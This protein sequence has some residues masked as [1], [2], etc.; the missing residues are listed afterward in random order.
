MTQ[1][2]G[3][4]VPHRFEVIIDPHSK[5]SMSAFKKILRNF[6]VVAIKIEIIAEDPRRVH[7]Y[8]GGYPIIVREKKG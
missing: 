4:R 8:K 7:G 6:Y 2:V 3:K 1:Q 5:T